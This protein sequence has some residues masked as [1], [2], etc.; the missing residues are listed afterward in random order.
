[1][2]FYLMKLDTDGMSRLIPKLRV[3]LE[4]TVIASLSTEMEIKKV[5]CHILKELLARRLDLK[6]NLINLS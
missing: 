4:E 3:A 5:L 6:P 1:M 2:D